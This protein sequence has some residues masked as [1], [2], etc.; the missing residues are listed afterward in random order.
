MITTRRLW[1]TLIFV[2]G[3]LEALGLFRAAKDD[4][5]SEYVWSKTG[6]AAI[7]GP[8]IGLLVWLVYHFSYG[9]GANGLNT[10]DAVSSV[11]GVVIGVLS[12]LFPRREV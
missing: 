2:A 7:R 8:V 12:V 10:W 9:E 3:A 1:A 5:L 6:K 4:T 11:V